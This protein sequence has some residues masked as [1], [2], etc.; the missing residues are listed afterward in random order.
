MARPY[1]PAI[2][3]GP[4]IV[5]TL[6]QAGVL[7]PEFQVAQVL[8]ESSVFYEFAGGVFKYGQEVGGG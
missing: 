7:R 8:L 4:D 1:F 3:E 5:G 2:Q 6:D